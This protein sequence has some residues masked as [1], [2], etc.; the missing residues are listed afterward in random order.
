MLRTLRP[1]RVISRNEGLKISIQSLL[2][3]I[4]NVFNVLL[5]TSLF[6]LI[7]GIM[8]VQYL[9][10]HLYNCYKGHTVDTLEAV[11]DKWSCISAGGEWINYIQNFD[12]IG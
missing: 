3:S 1:L 4:P 10:G 12:N 6:F 8:G 2:V 11:I 9:K 7:F 5:I